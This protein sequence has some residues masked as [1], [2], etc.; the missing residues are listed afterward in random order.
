MKATIDTKNKNENEKSTAQSSKIRRFKSY[1][2]ICLLNLG[3][4]RGVMKATI[5]TKCKK[6]KKKTQCKL[7]KLVGSNHTYALLFTKQ[8]KKKKGVMEAI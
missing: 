7:P 8:K 3:K 2:C 5:D 1:I 4:T 6:R